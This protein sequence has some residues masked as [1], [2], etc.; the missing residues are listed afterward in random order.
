[1][2]VD[3]NECVIAMCVDATKALT[4]DTDS[5]P[6]ASPAPQEGQRA[7]VSLAGFEGGHEPRT[8][9]N[10]NHTQGDS[11]IKPFPKFPERL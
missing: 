7:L 11:L 3:V 4:F 6:S 9:S 1:M 10:A 8:I 2:R 5:N